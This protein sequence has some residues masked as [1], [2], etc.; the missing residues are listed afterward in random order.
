MTLADA[1][2]RVRYLL[3][4]PTAKMWS[5]VEIAAWLNDGQRAMCVRRGIEEV[6]T[7][8]LAAA[9]EVWLPVGFQSIYKVT[10]GGEDVTDTEYFLFHDTLTFEDA[11]T[12][13]VKVYGTRAPATVNSGVDFELPDPYVEGCIDFA[14]WAAN[15]KDENYAEGGFYFGKF[16]QKRQEWEQ[17]KKYV[18]TRM[19]SRWM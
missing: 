13:T 10:V 8:T 14:C 1:T 4:E 16:Q 2:A 3:D 15:Q 18:P 6:W 9:T 12:G 7:G 5:D 11:Q 17:S 19:A